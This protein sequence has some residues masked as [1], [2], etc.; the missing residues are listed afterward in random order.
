VKHI[1]EIDK[2]TKAALTEHF[3]L[4]NQPITGDKDVLA[5]LLL[6]FETT[7]SRFQPLVRLDCR[8]QA[9]ALAMMRSKMM[10]SATKKLGESIGNLLLD[11]ISVTSEPACMVKNK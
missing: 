8:W 3:R 4:R 2:L 5:K 7:Y 10:M 6:L 1:L 11:S 9:L